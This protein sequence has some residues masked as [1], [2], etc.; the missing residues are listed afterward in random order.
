MNAMG[1]PEVQELLG[2]FALD[3]IDPAEADAVD[4]HLRECAR[5][6]A[7]VET[8]RETAALLAFAGVDAPS[9]VWERIQASLEE[10]PP[11]LEL[12]R[13][14]PLRPSRWQS[15]GA[16]LAAA[17]AVVISLAALSV[18][19]VRSGGQDS[20]LED[21]IASAYTDPDAQ[22]VHLVSSDG[23]GSADV[24]LVASDG[25][26]YLAK[27]SLPELASDE[28]YQLW[29]QRGAT[30]VSLG[31]L[32]NDPGIV[33]LPLGAEYDALAITAE[34]KPGVV[35]SD[36]PAVVAGLVPTA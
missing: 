1:H 8:F 17:A 10:A 4:L 11:K 25:R 12:A 30:K 20:T 19:M 34:K 6:R 18:A 33:R 7:E 24:L 26:A 14:V 27:H 16:K 2:A 35:A 9:G 23:K 32:G 29:G 21:E 31:V 15:Y 36:H 13:V 22:S 28:T 3:A 5:C